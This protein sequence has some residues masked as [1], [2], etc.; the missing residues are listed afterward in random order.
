[1]IHAQ[2]IQHAYWCRVQKN[3]SVF[4]SG[5]V[6]PIRHVL[7]WCESRS[8]QLNFRWLTWAINSFLNGVIFVEQWK[9]CNI[10]PRMH[11]KNQELWPVNRKKKNCM[12]HCIYP[13]FFISV[14]PMPSPSWSVVHECIHLLFSYI[15]YCVSQIYLIIQFENVNEH[16][17][18]NI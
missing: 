15:G 7:Q 10:Y 13:K 3:Y 2:S 12:S 6:M 1:M 8:D 9:S 17:W 5:T 4:L 11:V 16:K 14:G 18:L